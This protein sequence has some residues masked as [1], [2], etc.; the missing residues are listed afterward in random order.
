MRTLQEPNLGQILR[1]VVQSHPRRCIEETAPPLEMLL[2]FSQK[3]IQPAISLLVAN[4]Q[5]RKRRQGL[6]AIELEALLRT[7]LLYTSPSPRDS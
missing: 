7:C 5:S 3:H 2:G 4:P 6:L 1:Q